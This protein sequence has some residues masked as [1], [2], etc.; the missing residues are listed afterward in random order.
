MNFMTPEITEITETDT[1]GSGICMYNKQLLLNPKIWKL[2][3]QFPMVVAMGFSLIASLEHG[4]RTYY[5]PSYQML[6]FHPQQNKSAICKQSEFFNEKHNLYKLLINEGYQ[7]V[8]TRQSK[9][10][11]L[12]QK[13]TKL[14]NVVKHSLK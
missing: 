2:S 10:N 1:G 7:P 4:S 11:S 14:L 5:L 3:Q 8:L 13:A 9:N 12:A 6:K